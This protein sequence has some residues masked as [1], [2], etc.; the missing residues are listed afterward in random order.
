MQIR[1]KSGNFVKRHFLDEKSVEKLKKI[2]I[3]A[4]SA[5]FRE[6]QP[7][8]NPKY[9]PQLRRARRKLPSTNTTMQ[10][11]HAESDAAA[12]YEAAISRSTF[13]DPRSMRSLL[14]QAT[15]SPQLVLG[16]CEG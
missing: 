4:R 12:G 8:Q 14:Q 9:N 2:K 5:K 3:K 11:T 7:F 15:K 1:S 16:D 13:H 6:I 10:Q